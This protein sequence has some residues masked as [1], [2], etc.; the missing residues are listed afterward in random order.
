MDETFIIPDGGQLCD[1]E[2]QAAQMQLPA[3]GRH[4]K[5]GCLAN[6]INK[7]ASVYAAKRIISLLR[8]QDELANRFWRAADRAAADLSDEH[9]NEQAIA[10]ANIQRV[11]SRNEQFFAFIEAL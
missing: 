7:K 9:L 1:W 6:H 4:S 10:L 3:Y 8:E 5:A 2:S 11:E